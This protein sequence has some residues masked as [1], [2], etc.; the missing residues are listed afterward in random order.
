MPSTRSSSLLTLRL[1]ASTTG[2]V[3][4]IGSFLPCTPAPTSF[5]NSNSVTTRLPMSSLW[6]VHCQ[7]VILG[8]WLGA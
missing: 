3:P 6:A 7:T 5:S 4:G 2:E 1:S 8:L